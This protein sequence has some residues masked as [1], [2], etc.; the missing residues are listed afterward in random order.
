MFT[1]C[2]KL[3]VNIRLAC[4]NFLTLILLQ[5]IISQQLAHA[6]TD[7][8]PLFFS[9]VSQLIQQNSQ[10]LNLLKSTIQQSSPYLLP[11]T[12]LQPPQLPLLPL[13]SPF[14]QLH[15]S[16]Q[17]SLPQQLASLQGLFPPQTALSSLQQSALEQMASSHQQQVTSPEQQQQ[18][19][20]NSPQQQRQSS[21]I[22]PQLQQTS[23]ITPRQLQQTST[24]TPRQLQQTSTI[25]PQQQEQSS[26]LN[27]QQQQTSTITPQQQQTS[28][29]TPQ[30]S[31]IAP[32]QQ[33]T[34]MIIPQQVEKISMISPKQVQ[35]TSTITPQL[36][37]TS[38]IIPQQQQTS[39]TTPQQQQTSTIIPQQVEKISMISPQLVQQTSMISAQRKQHSSLTSPQQEQQ[40]SQQQPFT[41]TTPN[42]QQQACLTSPQLPSNQ[43]LTTLPHQTSIQHPVPQQQSSSALSL[44]QSESQPPD[45]FQQ[46]LSQPS[47]QQPPKSNLTEDLIVLDETYQPQKSRYSS[48]VTLTDEFYN[49]FDD[50]DYLSTWEGFT[51]DDA[52]SEIQPTP[53]SRYEAALGSSAEVKSP[54]STPQ[55][56]PAPIA[57]SMTI[58][59]PPFKTPPKLRQ[60]EEVMGD[61]G[62][63]DIASLRNLTTALAREAIFGKEEL[64]KKSLSGRRN[65]G[66]LDKEKL[67]YI[68]TLVKSRVPGMT[69]VE[70]EHAWTLCRGSLSKSCQALRVSSKRNN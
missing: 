62:G 7:K 29:I 2:C 69:Q 47:L 37:Q 6:H 24:I 51:S 70:F 59:P 30:T 38:T 28:T 39:T 58:P 55:R 23:R 54:F 63:T 56:S 32:Q 25:T 50:S 43:V 42:Q 49:T 4:V 68:K 15:S 46:S 10:I 14:H 17:Q 53:T 8:R 65:T 19:L 27:P 1:A 67:G 22:T 40:A 21:S 44:F 16:F 45:S 3:T 20:L 41:V 12:G 64:A 57:N 9:A 60:V 61:H 13:F 5:R 26:A 36:Q 18:A 31:T 52:V 33:Q 34:S 35:Q 48:A 11:A 66:I